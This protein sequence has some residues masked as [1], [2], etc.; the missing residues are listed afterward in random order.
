MSENVQNPF[1][2]WSLERYNRKPVE[3]SLLKLQD[4]C[5]FDVNVALWCCWLAETRAPLDETTL[6]S[7]VEE[8]R[9]WTASVIHPLRAARRYL[10]SIDDGIHADVARLRDHVKS[11]ELDA[12]K[13]VQNLLFK[14]DQS[15]EPAKATNP[16][17]SAIEYL[18]IYGKLLGAEKNPAFSK[19]LLQDLVDNIF[20]P[21]QNAA[22]R[23][24]IPA[25][26]QE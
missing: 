2:Q 5:G 26:K 6:E 9:E 16:A 15:S 11:A 13:H 4:E 23:G 21:A 10:K 22:G 1:W 18:S 25:G 24:N 19:K 17:K 3:R 8:K 20:E 7:A 14:F 12:E